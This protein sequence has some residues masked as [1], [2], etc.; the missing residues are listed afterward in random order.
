MSDAV[1]DTS[2]DVTI[3]D[4]KDKGVAEGKKGQEADNEVD[5]QEEEGDDEEKVGDEDEEA[6]S[7]TG[8]WAAKDDEDDDVDTK[9]QKIDEDH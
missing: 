7:A 5:E 9:K 6:E 8:K 1:V 3:K 2:S 4:L